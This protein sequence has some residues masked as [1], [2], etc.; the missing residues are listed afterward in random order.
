MG[1]GI[2][3]AEAR[4]NYFPVS[5]SNPV[6]VFGDI[7]TTTLEHLRSRSVTLSRYSRTNVL[8]RASCPASRVALL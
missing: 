5:R 2:L 3:N 7:C 1:V 4:I 6:A 8:A